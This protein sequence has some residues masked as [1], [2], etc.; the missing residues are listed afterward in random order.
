MTAP[1]VSR[2][3]LSPT[4]F[5]HIGESARRCSTGFTPIATIID[6]LSWLGLDR[7][8]GGVDHYARAERHREIAGSPTPI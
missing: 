4:G 6:G 1:V 8:R 3:A 2:F 7:D 5:L